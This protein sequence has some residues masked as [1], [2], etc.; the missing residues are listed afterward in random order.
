M[1]D[2]LPIQS[3]MFKSSKA[4]FHYFSY[5]KKW[6]FHDNYYY[7]L[8]NWPKWNFKKSLPKPANYQIVRKTQPKIEKKL[9]AHI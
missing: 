8:K 5:Y 7:A 1:K 3:D 9:E 2:Y 4:E 6:N